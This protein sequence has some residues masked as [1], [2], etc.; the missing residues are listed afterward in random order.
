MSSLPKLIYF[1]PPPPAAAIT[2]S[3]KTVN[4]LDIQTQFLCTGAFF[5]SRYSL[6]LI[7]YKF[8]M[9]GGGQCGNVTLLYWKGGGAV[10]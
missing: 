9:G 3:L 2:G 4:I 7:S 5:Y 6:L 1:T 10:R 8:V